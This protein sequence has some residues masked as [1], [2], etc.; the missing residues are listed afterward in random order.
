MEFI[1]S[2]IQMRTLSSKR[3]ENLKNALKL[4]ERAAKYGA[5]LI[6]FPE[7]FITECPSIHRTH[8]ELQKT[9]EEI[10]GG[11]IITEFCKKAKE[12]EAYIVAGTILEKEKDKIYNTS[13]LV[14]PNGEVIGKQRK[15]H[16]ENHA[17]KH[18][19]G[20]GI[21][22]A[23][24]LN[25]FDTELGKISILVDVDANVPEIPR[26][27]SLR[28]ADI[29]CW[30]LNWSVRWAYLIPAIAS[31][32]AYVTQCYLI[33]SDRAEVREEQVG[34][35]PLYYMGPSVIA[36]PEGEIIGFAGSFYEGMALAEISTEMLS[37]I[38]AYNK[39]IYPLWRRASVFKDVIE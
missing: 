14:G 8:D 25:V 36:N 15:T 6:V 21:T 13:V 4:V 39:E 3:N 11:P 20:L 5:K 18:E 16:P 31:T 28:G 27:Y 10:P 35:Y 29:I 34:P 2:A 33:A 1:A 30:P 37:K 24:E 19:V 22:P 12:L 38:R 23:D 7:Y 26:I 9:A 17:S 32:Y